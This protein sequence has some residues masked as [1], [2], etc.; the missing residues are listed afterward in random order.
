MTQTLQGQKLYSYAPQ[1]LA[2]ALAGW[3]VAHEATNTSLK[4]TATTDGSQ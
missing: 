3:C 2:L 1:A 4:W